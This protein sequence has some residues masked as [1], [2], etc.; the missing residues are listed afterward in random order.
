MMM[1]LSRSEKD[2]PV[3]VIDTR[4]QEPY[5]F[6]E[7][8]VTCQRKALP[9]GDY[10]LVGYED[11][12]AVERKSLE[13]FV[14]TLIQGRKRFRKELK[15]LAQYD[16]ACVVVEAD[17]KHIILGKYRSH[18]HPRSILG[19]LVSIHV[20]YG[21]PVICCSDRQIAC[22]FVAMF[23]LRHHKKVSEEKCDPKPLNK[24]KSLYADASQ[25]CSIRDRDS[26]REE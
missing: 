10:S 14:S 20:D 8:D 22:H 11:T 2:E 4:E 25:N 1:T 3:I 19:S 9:A 12:V 21:I 24:E 23:L 18:A 7:W 16:A 17:M 26:P 13:D 15:R 6:D 5:S